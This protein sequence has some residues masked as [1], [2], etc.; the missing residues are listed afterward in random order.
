[1]ADAMT[2]EQLSQ[3]RGLPVYDSAGDKIGQVEEIFLDEQTNRPEWVGVGTGFFGTKRVLVPVEGANLRGD[4]LDVP[5]TKDQIKDS[6]DI[7]GDD[8]N[9]DTESRL[10]AHYGLGYSEQRSD[11][12]LPEGGGT[13]GG[14]GLDVGVTGPDSPGDAAMSTDETTLTRSEEELRVGKRQ[15]EAGRV[16]LRKWVETAPVATDVELTRETVRVER[17]PIN[18]PV[19]GAEIGEEQVDVTLR[20]EEAVV[21]KQTVAKERIG[22]DKDVETERQTIQDEVRREQVEIE[23]DDVDTVG[24]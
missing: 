10:Y 6:P 22:L 1:M 18:Q 5:Y 3:A 2:I 11:T 21:D 12:G 13:T 16:R 7:D 14:G 23:G 24:R 9:Q 8:I 4:A 15:V 20:A 19:S 17:E